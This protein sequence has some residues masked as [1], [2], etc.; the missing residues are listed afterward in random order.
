MMKKRQ[1]MTMKKMMRMEMLLGQLTDLSNRP[2]LKV[3]VGK[4]V[5]Q[6]HGE[7][8]REMI[9]TTSGTSKPKVRMKDEA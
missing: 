2:I 6:S 3:R 9:I 7:R 4:M 1:M 5:Q 8:E